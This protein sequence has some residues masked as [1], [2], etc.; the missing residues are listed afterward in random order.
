LFAY[1]LPPPIPKEEIILH[2]TNRSRDSGDK[3]GNRRA[4]K[5]LRTAARSAFERDLVEGH[6]SWTWNM[7]KFAS[8]TDAGNGGLRLMCGER[9]VDLLHK[10]PQNPG[11]LSRR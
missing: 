7:E 6:R 2:S 3:T 8:R 9:I 1:K 4:C 5:A 10:S 11:T